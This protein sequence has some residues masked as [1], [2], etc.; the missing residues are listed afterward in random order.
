VER[1][2]AFR[3]GLENPDEHEHGST[4]FFADHDVTSGLLGGFLDH[5]MTARRGY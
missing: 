3:A 5:M 4:R 1:Y 2:E